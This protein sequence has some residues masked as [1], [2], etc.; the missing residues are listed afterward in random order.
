[1]KSK[2]KYIR[3]SMTLLLLVLSFHSK[4]YATNVSD[5]S[6][7]SGYD[8]KSMKSRVILT[9]FQVSNH[10]IAP[11]DEFDLTATLK[12]PSKDNSV[13]S[14]IVTHSN[15]IES[16]YGVY[17]DSDQAFIDELEPLQS[18]TI[19]FRLKASEEIK[20]DAV[21]LTFTITFAD[22]EFTNNSNTITV[23]IPVEQTSQ[24]E[25]Q[26]VS[27]PEN[28]VIDSKTRVRVTY[29][30]SGSEDLY[31]IVMKIDGISLEEP[32]QVSLGTLSSS[33]V[34]YVETYVKFASIGKK[35]AEISF[36]YEDIKGNKFNTK[37]YKV[38]LQVNQ[39]GKEEG[40]SQEN[41]KEKST[42]TQTSSGKM[43][44]VKKGI[45]IIG[46]AFM[47]VVVGV[48]FRKYKD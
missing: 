27:V 25:I 22:E 44:I 2:H 32:Q 19:K 21:M 46:I 47:M 17:G 3:L 36:T 4:S 8:V 29:K 42:I 11:G 26:A 6:T 24:L 28:A 45:L 10:A 39:S 14:L 7:A 18:E 40:S 9:D 23:M 41:V 37:A 13:K 33:K 12:N 15:E 5:S 34:N 20:T 16:V 35:E 1:M 31:N 30:N 48:L 38:S 43:T